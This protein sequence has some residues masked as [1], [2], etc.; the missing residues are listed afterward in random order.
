[1]NVAVARSS[2]TTQKSIMASNANAM[3]PSNL[4]SPPQVSGRCGGDETR[5]EMMNREQ[6]WPSCH[7]R[8]RIEASRLPPR[9]ASGQ[10]V[11]SFVGWLTRTGNIGYMGLW[12]MFWICKI[13]WSIILDIPNKTFVYLQ[14]IFHLSAFIFFPSSSSSSKFM[15]SH[16]IIILV[17]MRTCLCEFFFPWHTVLSLFLVF[18]GF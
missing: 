7:H 16:L 5:V 4:P 9:T 11:L 13:C 2:R 18:W 12:M 17:L 14:V 15:T 6:K 3:S 10:S 8:L 1:M